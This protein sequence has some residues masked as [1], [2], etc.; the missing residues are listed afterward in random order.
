[1]TREIIIIIVIIYLLQ[2][3]AFQVSFP[4]VKW[5]GCRTDHPPD[6]GAKVKEGVEPYLSAYF[7]SVLSGPV[8]G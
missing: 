5:L 3:I 8:L 1:V 4:G 7:P 2:Y 6:S